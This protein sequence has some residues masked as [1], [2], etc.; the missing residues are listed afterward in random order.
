MKSQSVGLVNPE[1][2]LIN[3]LYKLLF[4][5]GSASGRRLSKLRKDKT[6]FANI[7]YGSRQVYAFWSTPHKPPLCNICWWWLAP[8]LWLKANGQPR[9]HLTTYSE[10]CFK[11]FRC[12][13]ILNRLLRPRIWSSNFICI[14]KLRLITYVRIIIYNM[15]FMPGCMAQDAEILNA[16]P[17]SN[18]FSHSNLLGRDLFDEYR[19]S[20]IFF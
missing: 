2:T 3:Q 11:F 5:L 8:Q 13:T 15:L 7:S 1:L 17:A 19:V 12:N 4:V 9:P 20:S 6:I 18:F 16:K 14:Y 10:P